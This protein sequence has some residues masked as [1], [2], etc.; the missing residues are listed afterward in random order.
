MRRLVA[1]LFAAL[2]LAVIGAASADPGLYHD[3]RPQATTVDPGF[4]HDI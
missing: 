3:I 2:A 1:A 4:Y